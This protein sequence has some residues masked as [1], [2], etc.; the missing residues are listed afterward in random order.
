[1]NNSDKFILQP[2]T[3]SPTRRPLTDYSRHAASSAR[4]H[5]Y[6]RTYLHVRERHTQPRAVSKLRTKAYFLIHRLARKI[7]VFR[8]LRVC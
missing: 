7:G 4:G 6:G 1:M 2:F 3:L 5:T 8:F